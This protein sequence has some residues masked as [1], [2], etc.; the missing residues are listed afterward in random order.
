M[1]KTGRN[2]P[3]PCGS[4]K[5]FKKCCIDKV[6]PSTLEASRDYH[7]SLEEIEELTTK[8]II[9]KLKGFGVDFDEGQFQK[10]V[11]SFYSACELA[12]HW[13]KIFTVT[14]IWFDLDF[15]WMA[16]IVLW[17]RLAPDVVNSEQ[18][19]K[20][21]QKGY[22]LVLAEGKDKTV[23][24]CKLWLQVWDHIK[25]RFTN[26]MKSIENAEKVFSGMQSLYNW[27]QDFEQELHNAG[28]Y[29]QSFYQKRIEYCKEFCVF[30]P[31]SDELIILNMKRAE[32]ESY[33]SLGKIEE[34]NQA[35]EVLIKEFP[36]NVWGYIGWADMY[37]LSK[38][39]GI[40]KNLTKAK[41]IYQM[42]LDINS[43]EK[44]Y[45]IERLESLKKAQ[46]C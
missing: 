28:N 5:K 32:A 36:D 43:E 10:D 37:Y 22:D 18:L 9:S 7:W 17:K 1:G 4:G 20:L 39:S 25:H 45:V 14:A 44:K 29:D 42:A 24:G 33:F 16:C 40:E 21:M 8:E 19:D 15:I 12:D 11:R 38:S 46:N 27:C 13:G 23:E 41:E 31:N 3:C 35:F 34:G 2:A 6:I 30:F 26:D